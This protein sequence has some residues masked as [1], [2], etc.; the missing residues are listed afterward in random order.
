MRELLR[1]GADG[2]GARN[3]FVGFILRSAINDVYLSIFDTDGSVLAE[4]VLP[5]FLAR[6]Y[7]NR[8]RA[9]ALMGDPG[10]G[11]DPSEDTGNGRRSILAHID[12]MNAY[13][14][15]KGDV[16]QRFRG[17]HL[18]VE[19]WLLPGHT[20]SDLSWVESLIGAYGAV[21]QEL[22]SAHLSPGMT[23]VAD[24]A[25]AKAQ[26]AMS[27]Q[28]Q[29]MLDSVTRLVLMQY[30]RSTLQPVEAQTAQFLQGLSISG[31]NHGVIVAIRVIDFPLPVTSTTTQL[32][33][34]LQTNSAYQ[35][36][37]I[38]DYEQASSQ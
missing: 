31:D 16:T 32:Q 27:P 19:P 17:A 36:W 33:S 2:D 22:A 25:G 29:R 18:D 11:I 20:G 8:I 9:E 7:Q 1:A 15:A 13:N 21:S 30:E 34:D 3:D 38:F 24:V 37:T 23:L 26:H 35:G 4:P 6:L 12:D 14:S 28:R 10:W 5:S